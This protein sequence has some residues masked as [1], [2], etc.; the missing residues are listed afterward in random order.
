MNVGLLRLLSIAWVTLGVVTNGHANDLA[1]SNLIGDVGLA[2]YRTPAVTHAQG[3]VNSVLPYVYADYGPLYARV[4]T[5]GYKVAPLGAGHFELATRL[6]L[7]G[8]QSTVPGVSNRAR[9]K[10]VGV[11]TF[12][13]T[14]Y[15]AFIFYA[16]GDATSHG[17]LIDLTYAAEFI[18]GNWHVYPQ[19]GVERRDRRY[20]TN[21]YGVD[22]TD[23]QRSGLAEYA[24]G[25][26]ASPNVAA[27]ME[28]P[29]TESLKLTFQLKK[30]WL[31][32]SI[33]ESP[34]VNVRQQTS[35]LLA[36]SQSFK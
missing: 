5:F 29:L 36:I 22:A 7:E 11:G 14:P 31:D 30:R 12:Q 4:D 21:L 13:E 25:Y 24:P 1:N 2:M 16:F 32:R 35:G 10:P 15:G 3:Q 17:S 23:A 26:S 28:Y 9:P 34:L 27:A 18:V 20:V 19:V 8:Y 6:S 33:Y